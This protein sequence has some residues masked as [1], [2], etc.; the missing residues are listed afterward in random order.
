MIIKFFYINQSNEFIKIM[1]YK[2]EI[3]KKFKEKKIHRLPITTPFKSKTVTSY[4]MIVYSL[5]T[6]RTLLVKRKH[7]A[8]FLIIINGCYRESFL[9]DY[10]PK[11]TKDE[12][13]KLR[14]C[15][16]SK[17]Y[18]KYLYKNIGNNVYFFENSFHKFYS[19]IELIKT[20]YQKSYQLNS[21]SKS[22]LEWNWPKG[23]LN[24]NRENYFECAKREFFEEVECHLPE[25]FAIS[26]E[27]IPDRYTIFG[28][29]ILESNYLIYIVEDEFEIK[30]PI[31]N[32]EVSN[33]KWFT[34]D[35]LSLKNHI[36]N[37]FLN[38]IRNIID[39]NFIN[40]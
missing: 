9:Y 37:S 27:W 38:Q 16:T 12:S 17:R 8:Q 30:K 13:Q 14:K 35:E 3:Y 11:I 23:K 19:N 21:F 40:I 20:I 4:G 15:L 2:N 5:S 33:R 32:P 18:Y 34:F 7:S 24:S 29:K 1:D 22:R 28:G 26:N 25:Y 10:I 6:K 31:N 36:K 39:D